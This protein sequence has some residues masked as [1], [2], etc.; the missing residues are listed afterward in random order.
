MP[1][2]NVVAESGSAGAPTLRATN[3]ATL[4]VVIPNFNH[5]RYLRE[6]LES[7]LTQS[8]AP[9]EV[10]VIDDASTDE[11]VAIIEDYV[12]RRPAVRLVRHDRNRGV[13]QNVNAILPEL[14]GT[15]VVFLAADDKLLPGFFET[16]TKLL[17][18][19]PKAGMCLCDFQRFWDDGRSVI[20]RLRFAPEAGYVS[21][22]A[23]PRALY[24]SWPHG[25]SVVRLAALLEAG[26]YR[27]ELRWHCD[28]FASWA[29]CIRH[30]FCYAPVVGTALRISDGSFS[31]QGR[32]GPQQRHVLQQILLF[33]G[34]DPQAWLRGPLRE[35]NAFSHFG[36][37]VLGVLLRTS[38]GREFL[39]V[40][41]VSCLVRQGVYHGCCRLLP[42]AL[43]EWVKKNLW[44][45]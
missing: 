26:G 44:R 34:T 35:A 32:R 5:A 41:L 23:A 8:R 24:N 17:G 27:E 42:R 18:E 1:R 39:T 7:V 29:I 45:P 4:S 6:A 19:H 30:G 31:G 11:S 43:K 28:W 9:L 12:A 38:G 3:C 40:S 21:A 15:H 33:L 22:A 14:M 2:S 16:A 10:I 25:Q 20:Q 13:I 37:G 36:P